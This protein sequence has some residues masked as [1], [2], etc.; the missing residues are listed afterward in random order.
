[1]SAETLIVKSSWPCREVITTMSFLH[2]GCT[3]EEYVMRQ[4]KGHNKP[5][6]SCL[7]IIVR[8]YI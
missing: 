2:N 3:F 4:E 8:I 6:V 7:K 1:M 5:D